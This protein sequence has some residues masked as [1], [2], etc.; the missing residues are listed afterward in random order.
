MPLQPP[1]R[2][3]S[4]NPT[5]NPSLL[6]RSSTP[7]NSR[8][9]PVRLPSMRETE[10]E[11]AWDSSSDK[12]DHDPHSKGVH[13]KRSSE[14]TRPGVSTSWAS[15]SYQHVSHP[16]PPSRPALGSSKTYTGGAVPPKPG[17]VSNGSTS[18]LPPGGAWEIVEATEVQV[19][20]PC[21][22]KIGESAVREDLEDVL[23]GTSS[24]VLG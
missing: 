20:E 19:Q 21:L 15:T 3:H 1:T 17:T 5:L 9:T 6:P 10:W 18:K 12:E 14:S 7:T 4:A 24:G 11:D 8:P 2:P 22:E 23:R 13:K 16:S